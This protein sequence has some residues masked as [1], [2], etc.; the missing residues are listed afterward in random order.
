[1]KKCTEILLKKSSQV[2]LAC[3]LNERDRLVRLN[4]SFISRRFLDCFI[5]IIICNDYILISNVTYVWS[6]TLMCYLCN[7]LSR[8][9]FEC[10]CTSFRAVTD[11]PV[12]AL[13]ASCSVPNGKF[14]LCSYLWYSYLTS[15]HCMYPCLEAT[16]SSNCHQNGGNS[17]QTSVMWKLS[18]VGCAAWPWPM[19]SLPHSGFP[20]S[21]EWQ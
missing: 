1:M 16:E 13:I 10:T 7:F 2:R 18:H 11:I 8:K 15:V 21:S 19:K 6:C 12:G 4:I 20:Q 17:L 3:A 5:G 9:V 14:I